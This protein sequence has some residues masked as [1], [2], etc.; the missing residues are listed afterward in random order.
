MVNLITRIGNREKTE[1]G[2]LETKKF[3]TRYLTVKGN[4]DVKI[5]GFSTYESVDAISICY[6][7]PMEIDLSGRMLET[8]VGIEVEDGRLEIIAYR[9]NE[10][11]TALDEKKESIYLQKITKA[12]KLD[13]EIALY[14]DENRTEINQA[15]GV[16]II[17]IYS[18][19]VNSS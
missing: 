10:A 19:I 14:R 15:M 18:G 6:E 16:P 1:E 3:K 2:R 7:K 12:K 9:E 13:P 4:M 5:P 17:R 11:E 8:G